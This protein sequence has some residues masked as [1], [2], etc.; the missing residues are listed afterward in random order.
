MV[1][2][3]L[4]SWMFEMLILHNIL[5]QVN[6]LPN[7]SYDPYN[8]GDLLYLILLLTCYHSL[9]VCYHSLLIYYLP[10]PPHGSVGFYFLKK[11]RIVGQKYY[12]GELMF[13]EGDLSAWILELT[14]ILQKPMVWPEIV[15]SLTNSSHGGILW[16]FKACVTC[17]YLF[18][19]YLLF[20]TSSSTKLLY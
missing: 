15:A 4:M 3:L 16:I 1:I 12:R 7:L 17:M 20:I 6:I 10:F 19:I 14:F 5:Y 13:E 9:L 2:G 8:H 11:T 18:M